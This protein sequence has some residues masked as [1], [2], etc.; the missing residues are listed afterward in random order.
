L[1]LS[2]VSIHSPCQLPFSVTDKED[3]FLSYNETEYMKRA[4]T[5]VSQDG[6]PYWKSVLFWD[7]LAATV[8]FIS[9]APNLKYKMFLVSVSLVDKS[10]I[11]LVLYLL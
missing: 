2:L 1:L 7:T 3:L 4:K 5:V 8:G 6:T 11:V 10:L 9:H